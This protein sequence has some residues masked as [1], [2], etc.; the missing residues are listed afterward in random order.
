M[1]ERFR[2]QPAISQNEL[3]RGLRFVTYDGVAVQVMS[4]FTTGAFV[5]AFALLLGASNFMIGIIGALPPLT[6]ILQIPTIYLVE[7]VGYRKL[8]VMGALMV[9]S[10]EG[11]RDLFDFPYVRLVDLF[12][13]RKSK[14]APV[15]PAA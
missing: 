2:P 13:R 1:P 5:V 15:E 3:E 4:T 9:S 12:S 7:R 8:L 11:L 10:V 14:R 6:Q